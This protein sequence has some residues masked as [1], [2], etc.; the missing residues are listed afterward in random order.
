[1][2][3]LFTKKP[4]FQG[5]DEIHQL[6]VIYRV[7]GTPTPERWPGV[8]TMPWYELVKPKEVIPDPFR[9]LFKK[10]GT[11]LLVLV[12]GFLTGFHRWLSPAGMELAEELLHYDPS[13]RISA[14]Q[15]LQHPYFTQEQPPPQQP[16]G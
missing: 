3:E 16:T 1:M 7:L 12:V 5:T 11:R 2:L 8:T 15:A 13:K 10:Y 14:A 6:D 9:D 4:V